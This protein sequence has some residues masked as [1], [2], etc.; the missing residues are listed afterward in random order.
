MTLNLSKNTHKK[1][2]KRKWIKI[3]KVEKKRS[4]DPI[5]NDINIT[6]SKYDSFPE[7]LNHTVF[8][9][10]KTERRREKNNEIKLQSSNMIGRCSSF[11]VNMNLEDREK[12]DMVV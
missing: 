5:L 8:N 6:N 4:K 1:K 12:N 3:D 10:K 2:V 11:I 9:H 7:M